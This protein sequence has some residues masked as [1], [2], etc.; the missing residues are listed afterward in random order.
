M[1]PDST[2]TPPA[3]D[4]GDSPLEDAFG[5]AA[6]TLSVTERYRRVLLAAL[7][8]CD[9][10]PAPHN[11]SS[12]KS[13]LWTLHLDKLRLA[14]SMFQVHVV[15][16]PTNI[17]ELRRNGEGA[18]ISDLLM[19][20][21]DLTRPQVDL[22]VSADPCDEHSLYLQSMQQQ[23]RVFLDR[24]TADLFNKAD[25]TVGDEQRMQELYL[26]EDTVRL[27]AHLRGLEDEYL[28]D[29]RL[30]T[31][32]AAWNQAASAGLLGSPDSRALNTLIGDLGAIIVPQMTLMQVQCE[33]LGEIEF[34]AGLLLNVMANPKAMHTFRTAANGA[35]IIR[36]FY[37][38]LDLIEWAAMPAVDD[39]EAEAILHRR[40]SQSCVKKQLDDVFLRMV[41]EAED[42]IP[43]E[44]P[45]F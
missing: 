41:Q 33:M 21:F 40:Y 25:D 28:P 39:A 7:V 11:A 8:I 34:G 29:G 45:P 17:R 22:I 19:R 12:A 44:E 5:P 38:E 20:E 14:L 9:T 31:T 16:N 43:M 15:L 35:T 24:L 4:C 1:T 42:E 32:K 2:G 10:M 18:R 37:D 36:C 27:R 13:F 30:T 26:G 3:T 23:Y 6:K